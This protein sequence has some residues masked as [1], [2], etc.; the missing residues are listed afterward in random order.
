MQPQLLD[1]DLDL[2]GSEELP[3][4]DG[5]PVDNENQNTIPH[6]LSLVLWIIWGERQDWFFGSRMGVYDPE[7]QRQRAPLLI[8][9]AFLSIGVERHKRGDLGRLS[10]VLQE[11]QNIPPVLAL[12][13]IFQTYRGQYGSKFERYSRLGVKY[14]VI[15]NWEYGHWDGHDLFEVHKLVDGAYE[16]QEGEPYWM[17]EVG[18]GIG[19]VCGRTRGISREWLAWYDR[20]GKPY[21]LP[22]QSSQPQDK[23]LVEERRQFR[24]MDAQLA[25]ERR[26]GQ[27]LEEKLRSLGIDPDRPL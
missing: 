13:M 17:E 9:D 14:Y 3:C 6:W 1:L 23:E 8:P 2:P 22:W 5:A 10:Y 26:K 21:L 24:Q 15:Y 25:Q 18:L 11:E 7:G 27:Q 19:R 20:Q 16:R 12:E 4:S